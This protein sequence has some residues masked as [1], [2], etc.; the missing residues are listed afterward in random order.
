MSVATSRAYAPYCWGLPVAGVAS[1]AALVAVAGLRVDLELALVVLAGLLSTAPAAVVRT[2]RSGFSLSHLPILAAVFLLSPVW[3]PLLG[4]TLAAADN[5]RFGRRAILLNASSA[6]LSAAAA[7]AVFRFAGP[8]VGLPTDLRDPEWFFGAAAAAAALF[9]VNIGLAVA[10]ISLKY[11]E[12][13]LRVWRANMRPLVALD[14]LGSLA[15]IGFVGLMAGVDDVSLRVVVGVVAALCVCLLVTLMRRTREREEAL[16]SQEEALASREEAVM[17][18]EEALR[19]AEEAVL[20]A[21][22]AEG[23]AERARADAVAAAAGE[24]AASARAR[25]AVSRLHQIASGTVPALVAMIDLKD[26]YTARHSAGVGRLARMLAEE[27]GWTLEDQTLAHMAGLV[28]DIGKVGL[29]DGLLRKPGRPTDEE[30]EA[31]RRHPDWGADALAE[32]A[33][34]PQ[35]VAGVR[36][37]HERWDGSGYPRGLRNL[38]IPAIGR[39]LAIADSYDRMTR[40]RSFRHAKS[41]AVARAELSEQAGYLYDPQMVER[42]L[43]A[44]ARLDTERPI[45]APDLDF[46][47]EWRQ[48]CLGLDLDR[49]YLRVSADD[50]EEVGAPADLAPARG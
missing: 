50:P 14:I 21:T 39:I 16:A 4:A 24:Q 12:P 35:V 33:L 17:A 37:H 34:F 40:P 15:L 7:A 6:A 32:I 1:V 26:R 47:V 11:R 5:R 31:I 42:F 48:A 41:P 13:P 49:L 22:A 8:A 23:R 30:W 20:R 19:E 29:P 2:G 3:A 46:V 38:G 43:A 36:S 28:H 18:R 25:D 10:A 9:L 45:D 44:L 27:L